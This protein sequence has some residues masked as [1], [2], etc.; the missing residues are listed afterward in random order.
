MPSVPSPSK[1]SMFGMEEGN[2]FRWGK[3]WFAG[4]STMTSAMSNAV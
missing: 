1:E 3:T 4:F 2:C